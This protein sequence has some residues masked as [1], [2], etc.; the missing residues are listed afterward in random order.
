[1]SRALVHTRQPLRLGTRRLTLA[2][3]QTQ[4]IRDSLQRLSP[5]RTFETDTL[6][7]LDDKDK[8]TALYDFGQ[9]SLWT[10]ELE[11]KL[12]SGQLDVVVNCLGGTK[13]YRP[14]FA[15]S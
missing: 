7:T 6:H 5:S 15:Q 8:S 2:V 1:M 12:T 3:V 14:L 10:A 4:G 13:L 11:E 9:K